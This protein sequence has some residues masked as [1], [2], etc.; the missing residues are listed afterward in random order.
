MRPFTIREEDGSVIAAVCDTC[1]G[2]IYEGGAYYRAGGRTVCPAC[3][4][5]SDELIFV[6]MTGGE[7][8]W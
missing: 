3:L 8:L 5:E 1:G 6:R 4:E 7:G 2:E